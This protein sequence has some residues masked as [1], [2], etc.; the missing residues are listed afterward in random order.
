MALWSFVG[1][2]EDEDVK[3]AIADMIKDGVLEGKA[4]LCLAAIAFAIASAG[5]GGADK[6]SWR[7]IIYTMIMMTAA[8][9]S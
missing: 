1:G 2:S 3:R 6:L 4:I 9:H 7:H 5:G 8:L